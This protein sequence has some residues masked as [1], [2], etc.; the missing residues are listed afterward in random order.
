MKNMCITFFTVSTANQTGWLAGLVHTLTILCLCV[1]DR[2]GITLNL[3][4][5]GISHHRKC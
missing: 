2:D 1:G 5:F 4:V 3:G